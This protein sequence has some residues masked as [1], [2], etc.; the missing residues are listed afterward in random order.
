[1]RR[2]HGALQQVQRPSGH[3]PAS[4]LLH[5][6]H[7]SI[8]SC[9]GGNRRLKGNHGDRARDAAVLQQSVGQRA[10][11][12][13]GKPLLQGRAGRSILPELPCLSACRLG[14]GIRE[15]VHREE[16]VEGRLQHPLFVAQ[17]DLQSRRIVHRCIAFAPV[18]GVALIH[19][20]KR[21]VRHERHFAKHLLLLLL[22]IL[23]LL[24]QSFVLRVICGGDAIQQVQHIVVQIHAG[25]AA[26]V[27]DAFDLVA[28]S[29]ERHRNRAPADDVHVEEVALPLA[30]HVAVPRLRNQRIFHRRRCDG[31]KRDSEAEQQGKKKG[32]H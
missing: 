7:Q 22:W 17:D 16:I 2:L 23:L 13:P 6:L 30:G 8:F 3:Q 4:L 29:R 14:T 31:K 12:R 19:R 25:D 20:L 21:G 10:T 18:L 9:N 5:H 28:A 15:V 11:G 27:Q 24:G 26:G 32:N 1:M